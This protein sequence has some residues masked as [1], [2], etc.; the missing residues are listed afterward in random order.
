MYRINR[1]LFYPCPDQ[2]SF[3]DR[4]NDQLTKL[5]ALKYIDIRLFHEVKKIN[6]ANVKS[7]RSRAKFTKLILFQYE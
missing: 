4:H 6:D 3:L 5:V 1:E 7:G 2:E